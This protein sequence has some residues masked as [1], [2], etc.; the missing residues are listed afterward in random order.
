MASL[1]RL[2]LKLNENNQIA[3]FWGGRYNKMEYPNDIKPLTGLRF[4][5]ASWLL[6]YFF[7][8]RLGL[9]GAAPDV[10]AFGYM[11]VDLF[12]ILSGFVLAHVYGPQVEAGNYNHKG[13][14]WARLARIYPLHIIM[15]IVMIGIWI[16]GTKLGFSHDASAFDV[17]QI[18]FHIALLQAWGFVNSDGWNFPSW[19]ISAEWFAY[20]TFPISFYLASKF[21]NSKIGGLIAVSALFLAIYILT[22][23]IGKLELTNMTWEGGILRIIPA[24]MAGV[25]LWFIGR[26]IRLGQKAAYAGVF[27]SFLM[28]FV[29]MAI[30]KSP[31]MIWFMLAAIVFFFAETSKYEK[32]GIC[33]NKV[34]VYLGEISFAMYMVHLPVDILTCKGIAKF[35]TAF[36][37]AHHYVCFFA[38]ITLSLVAAISA[39]ELYEKPIRNF[40]RK[41]TP[42][43]IKKGKKPLKPVENVA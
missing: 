42:S 10:V 3:P 38:G 1:L 29:A 18:P 31:V 39:H 12:F 32:G 17:K 11:G 24:F 16:I 2:K 37:E 27:A 26:D 4:I 41:H 33:S 6:V 34:W 21:K 43:W 7:W 22:A 30:F 40:M 36:H 15:L 20:L 8:K 23:L 35:A 28:L 13:F 14:I 19:S 9:E 5:A 25:M